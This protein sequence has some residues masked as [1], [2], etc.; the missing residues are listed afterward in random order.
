MSRT[1][2][3][4]LLAL[5]L[6]LAPLGSEPHIVGKLR[7]VAGGANGMAPLD[8]FDLVLHGV[9]LLYVGFVAVRVLIGKGSGQPRV[10]GAEAREKIAAG[11]FLLDVRS[12]GEF[13]SGHLPGATN[14]PVQALAGRMGE[15]PAGKEVIVYCA[16][17]MRSSSAARLLKGAGRDAVFDLGGMGRW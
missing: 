6:G 5:F 1:T 17:G 10:S 11:A 7:W 12:P 2:I 13:A 9:P 4:V 16:S 8:W 3:G 15:V 14:I